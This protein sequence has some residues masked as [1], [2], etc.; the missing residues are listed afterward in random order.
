MPNFDFSNPSDYAESCR[1]LADLHLP[2]LKLDEVKAMVADYNAYPNLDNLALPRNILILE[3]EIDEAAKLKARQA[4]LEGRVFWEHAAAGEATRL[5]LGPKFL[6]QPETLENG[7]ALLPLNLGSRHMWQLAFEISRLAENQGLDP[8]LVLARQKLLLV[9]NESSSAEIMRI[10]KEMN[11]FGFARDNFFLM[12]Q[13]AF[14]GLV[15][16]ADGWRFSEETAAR[17]HNHGQLAMQKTM[18][19]QVFRLGSD[20]EPEYLNREAFFRCLGEADDLVSYNI[21]D[22]S[23]LTGA[24]DFETIGLALKLGE[25]G[26]GMTMEIV[27]NHPEH[28]VKGG[29]CAYDPALGR[30]VVIESF[31]L[32]NLEP[33]QIKYLNKN[34]NHYPKPALAF[35]KLAEEGLF[36][37]LMATDEGL[38]FQPVQGDLN[39]L[40]KTAM[41]SRRNPTLLKS[42][43]TADDTPAAIQ[44][45]AEQDSQPGFKGFLHQ[46]KVR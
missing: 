1:R 13:Q 9:T 21:E 5:G 41:I 30:D 43:K 16:T 40:V 23:Y 29:L 34:F 6:I 18:D 7:K 11:F 22:L 27:A 36:M 38:Y 25:Q 32:R 2:G 19:N 3:D 17:L 39:F 37:P 33:S 4:V 15:Q 20:G 10:L 8:A 45:M 28:P 31:R 35:G 12:I 42:W 46:H 14:R 44:A 26:F 24:L